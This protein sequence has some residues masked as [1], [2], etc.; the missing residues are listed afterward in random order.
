MSGYTDGE[1]AKQGVLNPGTAILHK[2]FTQEELLRRV[3]EALSG[4]AQ[5]GEHS[6]ETVR[7]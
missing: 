1:I 3:E 7:R 5:G 6:E 4:A 2:P